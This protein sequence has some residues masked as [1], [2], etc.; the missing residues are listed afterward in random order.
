LL[1]SY[2]PI[3]MAA[4]GALG[5]SQ[6]QSA[7]KL[8]EVLEQLNEQAKTFRGLT[9]DVERTK[10]TVVVND[11][12]VETGRVAI[13]RNDMRIDLTSP[14][15]RTIL[16]RGDKLYIYTPKL[17][18]VEEYD[19]GKHRALVDQFLLLGFGTSGK[20]LE[21]AYRIALLGQESL[22]GRQTVVLELTPKSKEVRNQIAKIKIWLDQS[23]WLPVQQKFFEAGTQD[24]FTIRYTN[25][26]RNPRMNQNAFKPRWPRGTQKIQPE[27]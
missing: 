24:Y 9:A 7:P 15:Q 25:A 5:I 19:L 2:L 3:V 20:S 27:I 11:R 10:V 22:A 4:L 18:R 1:R 23:S 6:A 17:K 12:S 13:S 21:K 8:P 16:R 14:D 26:I